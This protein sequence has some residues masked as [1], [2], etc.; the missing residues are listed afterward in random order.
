MKHE[1]N[2]KILKRHRYENKTLN[3][4]IFGTKKRNDQHVAVARPRTPAAWGKEPSATR[5]PAR[6][7]AI[8]FCDRWHLP[9][10]I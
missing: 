9:L 10:Q 6:H 5:M 8:L 2:L 7:H 1:T 3:T 4:S